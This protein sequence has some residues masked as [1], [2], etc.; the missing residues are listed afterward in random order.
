VGRAAAA[1]DAV[2]VRSRARDRRTYLLRPDLGRRLWPE[3]ADALRA[4]PA[5]RE[6][7]ERKYQQ[8]MR[9]AHK[10]AEEGAYFTFDRAGL[11][12]VAG[13]ALRT[14]LHGSCLPFASGIWL[15]PDR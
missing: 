13:A 2:R 10:S 6:Q 14:P 9:S 11:W 12:P 5:G 3:S 4:H 8:D 15:T 1:S 7:E